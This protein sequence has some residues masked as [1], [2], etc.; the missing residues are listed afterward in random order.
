M[1]LAKRI[2]IGKRGVMRMSIS[3][4]ETNREVEPRQ[5][6]ADPRRSTVEFRVKH[7]WGLRTVAGRFTRFDGTYTDEVE[8]A[9]V[10]LDIDATS[11]ETGNR[12]RDRHLRGTDFFNA[13]EHPGRRA[14]VP[15]PCSAR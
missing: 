8:G 12:Q 1:L 6:V 3:A 13:E 4:T 11:V 2:G 14:V 9:T 10:E 5:W 7:F 15:S